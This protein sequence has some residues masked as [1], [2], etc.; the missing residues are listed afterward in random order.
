MSATNSKSSYFKETISLLGATMPMLGLNLAIY[1]GFFFV[2]LIW[3][4]IWAGLAVLLSNLSGIAAVICLI[5][6]FGAG[7]WGWRMARRYLLYMVKGA[8]IAAMTEIM[9]GR[10]VP[11]GL[12]QISYGQEIIKKYFKN[13]SLLFGIDMIVD[14]VVR[15][16]TRTVQGVLNWLPL[17]GQARQLI[18]LI[19]KIIERS[20]SYVDEAILSYA[21]ARGE[22]NVFQSAR[23]GLVLYAQSYKPIL[24]TTVKFYFIAKIFTFFLFLGFVIPALLLTSLFAIEWLV[25]VGFVLAII[26]A[27]LVEL[28]LI[29]PFALA[30]VMVTFH[31]ETEGQ[32]P[33]PEWDQ[34]LQGISTKFKELIGRAQE[35]ADGHSNSPN[36]LRPGEAVHF[37][38]PTPDQW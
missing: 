7:G 24:I 21:I 18:A 25:I 8:H 16:F 11:R 33:N 26:A 22:E 4:A 31:R 34:K 38:R 17:P 5:I 30:Y 10:D 9:L 28:A 13:V 2:A 29:E 35:F 27:R 15:S 3:F 32:V 19:R 6:A 37:P 23:Q 12:G 1:A 20:A 14:G 36:P